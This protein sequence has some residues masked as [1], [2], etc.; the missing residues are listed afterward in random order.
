MLLP[1]RTDSPLRRTPY[2]NWG[3][4]LLN[5]F[6]AIAQAK[7]PWIQ[8]NCHLDPVHPQIY[9]FFTYQFMHGGIGHLLSNMLFLYIFGNNVNDKLGNL[10]YLAF[11]LAGGVFAGVAYMFLGSPMPM[12]GASGSVSAVTGAFLVLLPQTRITVLF[13]FVLIGVYEIPSLWFILAFFVLDVFNQFAPM[14]FGSGEGVAYGAHIGGSIFGFT[15]AVFLLWMRLLPR[16]L[17]DVVALIDRWSRRRQHRD[18]VSRGFDPFAPQPARERTRPDPKLDQI[19][20]LR[21]AISEAIAH[22]KL[23]D[24]SQLYARLLAIDPQQVL[25]RRTQLDVANELFAK[26]QYP[27]AAA[28]YEAYLR[29]YTRSNEAIDQVQLM[30]G[31]IYARYVPN[32]PRAKELLTS[33]V[34]NLTGEREREI[35]RMELQ[36]M[37]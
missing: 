27:S 2:V 13:V 1:I 26:E 8:Q 37:D 35:A 14:G 11:Y 22:D 28:A 25:S 16:D 10:A 18:L 7:S 36:K 19:Q 3:L 24:A 29:Q 20:E 34:N 5:V 21:A 33:A 12:I 31:L 17:F 4:I 23:T 15:V 6:A 30:L 32:R 9:Q